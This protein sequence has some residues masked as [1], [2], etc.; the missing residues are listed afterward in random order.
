MDSNIIFLILGMAVVTYI[1]RLLPLLYGAK[2][3]M[4]PSLRRWIRYVPV[5]V[6]AALV[7]PDLFFVEEQLSLH[8]LSNLKLLAAVLVFPVAIKSKSLLFTI[9]VGV[10]GLW[11][12]MTLCR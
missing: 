10:G 9:V 4:S 3:E 5:A 8:P 11:L 7:F 12:L 1:P 6:F 2:S